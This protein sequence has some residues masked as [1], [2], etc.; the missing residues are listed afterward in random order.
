LGKE[1][2]GNQSKFKKIYEN[3]KKKQTLITQFECVSNV[4]NNH[5]INNT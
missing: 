2:K 3:D 4:N 5:N 1:C